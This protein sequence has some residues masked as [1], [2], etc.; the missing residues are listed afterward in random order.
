[1]TDEIK[2]TLT[3]EDKLQ[4]AQGQFNAMCLGMLAYLK[5]HVLPVDE[6]VAFMG[7]RLA[8]GWDQNMAPIEFL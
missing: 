5:E 4:K 6:F 7:S 2:I 8:H 1:M 3:P